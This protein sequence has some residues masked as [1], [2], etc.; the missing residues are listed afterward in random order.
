MS[1]S[2]EKDTRQAKTAFGQADPKTAHEAQQRKEEK[3]N[4]RLYGVIAVVFVIIAIAC[5][6]YRSN[7]I[8]KM[9]TAATIGDE[10]YTAAE[11]N[12]YFVNNYQNFLSKN[13]N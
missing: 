5:L 12:Y 4:N 13:Y 2:K 6:V 9:V 8:P 1:A 11:V 3:R 7:I 10:S